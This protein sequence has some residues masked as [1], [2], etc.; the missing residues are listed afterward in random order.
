MKYLP[1][2]QITERVLKR[3]LRILMGSFCATF[4]PLEYLLITRT[5]RLL[6]PPIFIV[7]PPRSGTTLVYQVLTIA[8]NLCYLSKHSTIFFG[9]PALLSRITRPFVGCTP[10]YSFS[11]QFGEISGWN[12]PVA[13]TLVWKRWFPDYQEY[14]GAN[15]LRQEA[16]QQMQ[17]TISLIQ[18]VYA[19]PFVNKSQSHNGHII[20][21]VETFPEA[22]FIRVHRDPLHIAESNLKMKYHYG[23][24]TLWTSC[25]T[26]AY[27]KIKDKPY[28]E[29]ICKQIYWAEKDLDRDSNIVG[30]ERFFHVHYAQLCKDPAEICRQF[31]EFYS[32][33]AKG[34]LLQLRGKIPDFFSQSR[35]QV[36][37]KETGELKKHLTQLYAHQKESI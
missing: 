23:D 29:K 7:G 27:N 2:R 9:C 30:G 26:S 20:P 21:L 22:V 31:R 25:K 34:Y 37:E 36:S 14:V 12:A 17:K 6:F 28:I 11:S 32:Q 4:S 18:H 19:V 24:P 15:S 10:P 33:H 3:C 16:R 5:P 1:V 8:F 13:G 35:S